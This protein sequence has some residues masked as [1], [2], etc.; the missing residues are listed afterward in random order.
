MTFLVLDSVV[1]YLQPTLRLDKLQKKNVPCWVLGGNH[2]YQAVMEVRRS[3]PEKH[4]MD[5]VLVQIWWFE[6]LTDLETLEAIEYLA[7]HHNIDQEFRKD[8]DFVDRLNFL[9]RK[10]VR[11]DHEWKK[12]TKREA[13]RALGY[14]SEQSLNPL[15]QLVAGPKAKWEALRKVL[16]NAK[17][18]IGSEAKFRCLQGNLTEEQIIQLLTEV[19]EGRLTLEQMA[20]QANDLK[21]DARIKIAAAQ[22]LNCKT[23]AEVQQ[24]FGGAAFSDSKRRS[25]FAAFSKQKEKGRKKSRE[26]T[27][28]EVP[29]TFSVYVETVRRSAAQISDL[30]SSSIKP[31]RVNNSDHYIFEL[32]VSNLQQIVSEHAKFNIGISYPLKLFVLIVFVGLVIMDPP[33]GLKVAEWDSEA[34][35]SEALQDL[36]SAVCFVNS[37]NSF[38][39]VIFCEW[40][41]YPVYSSVVKDVF[42]PRV[43]HI[44]PLILLKKVFAQGPDLVNAVEVAVHARIGD[45]PLN[46]KAK[47]DGNNIF[48]STEEA[49]TYLKDQNNKILNP[50]QKPFQAIH[51]LVETYAVPGEFVLDLFAGTGQVM[52]AAADLSIGSVSIEKDPLQIGYLKEHLQKATSSNR[53]S[54]A[55]Y[56]TCNKCD[57]IIGEGEGNLTC[58]NCGKRMHKACAVQGAT[59]EEQFC[60]D[61]C[62][63]SE[64]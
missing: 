31:F 11:A 49:I 1:P 3:C 38:H 63:N 37:Q 40:N 54:A 29:E 13:A 18:K 61:I 28:M 12:E 26:G 59:D 4:F 16:L 22:L 50:A 36:L 34:F 10:Y 53:D 51:Q 60:S 24:R 32:D 20:S 23:F 45:K 25:F 44:G 6:N 55:T 9:R 35:S 41:M 58:R 15:L 8:W 2:S 30:L 43:S 64:I 19:A 46:L 27:V 5:K 14:A 56:S 42:G 52:K 48:G 47:S 7:A 17:E 33:Y 39:I 57:K 21:L 62:K